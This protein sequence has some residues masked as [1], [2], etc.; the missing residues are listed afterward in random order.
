MIFTG[1]K[2]KT[3]QIFFN[4]KWAEFLKNKEKQTPVEIKNVLVLVDD[5]K[6][7]TSLKKELPKMLHVEEN[8]IE[9]LLFKQKAG[10]AHLEADGYKLYTPKD[11][12]WYGTIKNSSLN[13]CLTKKYDLLINYHKVDNLYTNLL[14]LHS[15]SIFRAG[16][17][18]LNRNLYQLTIKCN[19]E[20]LPVFNSELKKY[21]KII[22]LL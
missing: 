19:R 17:E 8:A 22:N 12:G 2:R 20:D 9:I 7:I 3:N 4:K 1:F 21:L 10:K 6:I 16:F 13:K 18:H 11:F 14:L 15:N 5:E